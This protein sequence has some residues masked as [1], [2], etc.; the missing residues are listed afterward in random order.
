M[1]VKLP[2]SLDRLR[3]VRDPAVAALARAG[4]EM[5]EQDKELDLV[6]DK[7]GSKDTLDT[8]SRVVEGADGAEWPGK[9][10]DDARIEA[11]REVSADQG[12][13]RARDLM[14]TMMPLPIHQMQVCPRR[15]VEPESCYSLGTRVG[16]QRSMRR[17]CGTRYGRD[18]SQSRCKFLVADEG[19]RNDLEP[20]CNESGSR[21]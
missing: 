1:A 3:K 9:G 14:P 16:W 17:G 19:E 7:I 4:W 11:Q 20:S 6:L 8:R 5:L 15:T 10:R 2:S 21:S 12:R 13:A 18:A